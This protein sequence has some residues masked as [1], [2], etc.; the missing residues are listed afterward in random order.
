MLSPLLSSAI[1]VSS[2]GWPV[3]GSRGKPSLGSIDN[4]L[5][6]TSMIKTFDNQLPFPSSQ[7]QT[8]P[9]WCLVGMRQ[10]L[11]WDIA[12]WLFLD[13]CP[14]VDRLFGRPVCK[15]RWNLSRVYQAFQYQRMPHFL[16][17]RVGRDLLLPPIQVM[18]IGLSFAYWR[19]LPLYPLPLSFFPPRSR[20]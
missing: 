19:I 1:D 15:M 13:N 20:T 4:R 11:H 10:E 16:L 18:K 12:V 3:E 7:F 14:L 9:F 6:L 17:P 8:R 5:S 2:S